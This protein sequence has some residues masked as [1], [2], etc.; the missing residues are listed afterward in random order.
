MFPVVPRNP[1]PL[2]WNPPIEA[3]GPER[4]S[5]VAVPEVVVVAGGAVVVGVGINALDRKSVV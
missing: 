1:N 5:P 2:R 4:R 3:T